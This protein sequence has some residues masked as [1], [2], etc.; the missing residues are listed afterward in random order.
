MS[1]TSSSGWFEM[2]RAL[3]SCDVVVAR[4]VLDGSG[5]YRSYLGRYPR[6][7]QS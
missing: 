6:F 5:G 4:G 2:D 7:P 3:P 1:L